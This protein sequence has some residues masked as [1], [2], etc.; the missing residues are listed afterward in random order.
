VVKLLLATDSVD[1]SSKDTYYDRTPLS[2]A[3]MNGQKAVVKLLLL[4]L[5][6]VDPN[7]K[8]AQVRSDAAIV[9]GGERTRGRSTTYTS[10]DGVGESKSMTNL[11]FS[12]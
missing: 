10:S 4:A 5:D 2:W 8:D 11:G 1:L 6:G 3:A 12:H 9:G 7:S